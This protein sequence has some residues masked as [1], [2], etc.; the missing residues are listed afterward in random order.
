M[1][2][3]NP[4]YAYSPRQT[5]WSYANYHA[6]LTE[7]LSAGRFQRQAGD[8]LC[9]PTRKFWGLELITTSPVTCPRCI[10]LAERH[11]VTLIDPLKKES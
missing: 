1:L 9:K 7:P 10:E 3:A 4:A 2:T 8:A 6:V 5:A 11:G